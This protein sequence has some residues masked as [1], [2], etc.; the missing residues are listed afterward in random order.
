[1]YK[2]LGNHLYSENS[3]IGLPVDLN[4]DHKI[5]QIYRSEGGILS[6][7]M[8]W[9]CFEDFKER[10]KL[11]GGTK[12]LNWKDWDI[13]NIRLWCLILWKEPYVY[14]DDTIATPALSKK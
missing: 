11:G 5:Y 6:L 1:M 10:N 2:C 14:F 7:A 3:A 12:N 8:I 13:P 4:D 9:K